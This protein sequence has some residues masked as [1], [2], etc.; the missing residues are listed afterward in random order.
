MLKTEPVGLAD[1]EVRKRR[2]RDYSKAFGLRSSKTKV[3]T[4]DFRVTCV[5]FFPIYSFFP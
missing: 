4:G 5:S 3:M 1:R 2:I